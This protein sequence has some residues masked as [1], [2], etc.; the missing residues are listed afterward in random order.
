MSK[1]YKY[2]KHCTNSLQGIERF[3]I[4]CMQECKFTLNENKRSMSWYLKEVR[5]K[6][7]KINLT[8][9]N[10]FRFKYVGNMYTRMFFPRVNS[11]FRDTFQGYPHYAPVFCLLLNAKLTNKDCYRLMQ[12][13]GLTLKL[14]LK[15]DFIERWKPNDKKSNGSS[16]SE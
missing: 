4:S 3:I 12:K 10:N 11:V 2:I 8:N 14:I 6:E 9:T 7:I 13:A 5:G 16:T 15:T 1:H